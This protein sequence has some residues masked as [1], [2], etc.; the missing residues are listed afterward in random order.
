MNEFMKEAVSEAK[1]GITQG[2]GGPFGC[3]IVKNGEIVGR[4]H[5]EVVRLNDPTAHGEIMAIRNSCD[6]LG[7]YDLSGSEL[8]TTGEPCPM[9]LGAIMWANI[10]KVF[11]GCTVADADRIGFRDE[12]FYNR[13]RKDFFECIDRSQCLELFEEYYN[14]K[15]KVIY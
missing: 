8:Y 2:D 14:M 11:Y 7:T 9:C 4:G 6:A 5:N 1:T 13:Q 10:G 15:D 3:V 12:V